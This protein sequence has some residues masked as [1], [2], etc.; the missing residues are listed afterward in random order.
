MT[1]PNQSLR[2]V[3]AAALTRLVFGEHALDLA[4]GELRWRGEPVDLEPQPAKVLRC[5][6][7]HSG[8][9]VAREDL[10]RVLWGED[11]HVEADQG[12]NYCIK[13][14]RHALGDAARNPTFI[15]T[16][17]RRGYRFLPA[18]ELAGPAEDEAGPA[19]GDVE[20]ATVPESARTAPALVM[21]P[22]A[23]SKVPVLLGG[24]REKAGT[25][26]V[27]AAL[28]A[29]AMLA[30]GWLSG[31]LAARTGA[32]ASATEVAEPAA[33]PG[34]QRLAVLA[35]DA[36]DGVDEDQ[37]VARQLASQ[38][39]S[40]LVGATGPGFDVIASTTS[41]AYQGA[42]KTIGQIGR[43]LGVAYVVEGEFHRGAAPGP[44]GG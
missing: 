35:F 28:A 6:A 32:Q 22:S 17:P 18:V 26:I 5:L 37:D 38:L 10:Y 7:L 4:T 25:R 30:A 19:G 41:F 9:V 31:W 8:R 34:P 11:T 15:E 23:P 36:A 43:E 3:E 2:S 21:A 16:H 13:E 44:G 33:E 14:L 29:A 24:L 39:V 40:D 20:S 27:V 1:A 12:L 42:G